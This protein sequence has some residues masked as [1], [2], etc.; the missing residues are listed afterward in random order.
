MKPEIIANKNIYDG[1]IFNLSLAT[2]R[3]N[4]VTYQREIIS[5]YGSAVI[6]PVFQ[7]MTVALVKQYRHPAQKYLLEL[8]AGSL[9]KNESPEIG[10]IRELEEEIGVTAKNIE[11]LTEFYVSPGFLSEKMYVFL[12]TDLTDVGQK[13]EEDEMLEIERFSFS[14]ICKMITNGE[15]EDAKTMIGL[16]LAGTRLGFLQIEA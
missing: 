15:F 14:E 1:K 16:I 11:K 3:E 4:D 7:D 2:V 5:H 9:N 8:P 13:L 12:A 10:A 6:V